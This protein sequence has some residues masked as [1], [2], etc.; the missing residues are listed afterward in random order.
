M[1]C[2]IPGSSIHGIFQMRILECVAVSYSKLTTWARVC[3]WALCSISLCVCS[4]IPGMNPTWSYTWL[5]NSLKEIINMQEIVS[6]KIKTVNFKG[7][8]PWKLIGRTDAEA[9]APVFWSFDVNSWLIGKVPDA[10]KDWGQ[11]EKSTSEDEM[12]GWHHWCNGHEYGQTSGDGEGQEGLEWCSP[13]GLR[14]GHNRATEQ[15]LLDSVC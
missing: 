10:G 8:Q 3:F 14:V 7:N 1:D 2:S 6:K 9:E 12:A 4:Y 13:W 11:K 5:S 15:Q